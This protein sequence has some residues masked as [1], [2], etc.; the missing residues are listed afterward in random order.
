[1]IELIDEECVV[2]RGSNE[3][4]WFVRV[5]DAWVAAAKVEGALSEMEKNAGPGVVWRR[6]TRLELTHGTKL[7]KIERAPGTVERSA[8]EHLLKSRSSPRRTRRWVY[9]VGSHGELVPESTGTRSRP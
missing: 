7:L 4:N 8:L 2:A 6:H 5:R 3:I 9:S 1:M